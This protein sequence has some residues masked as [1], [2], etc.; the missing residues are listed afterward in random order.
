MDTFERNEGYKVLRDAL[1][2]LQKDNITVSELEATKKICKSNLSI[3]TE[4]MLDYCST[5]DDCINMLNR[6]QKIKKELDEI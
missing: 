3:I 1:L 6:S 2:T 5:P 4:I